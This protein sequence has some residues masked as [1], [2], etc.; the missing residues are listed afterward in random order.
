[1]FPKII[2]TQF[3]FDICSFTATCSLH[4]EQEFELDTAPQFKGN[5]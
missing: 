3:S 4:V 5:L 2:K 1:M